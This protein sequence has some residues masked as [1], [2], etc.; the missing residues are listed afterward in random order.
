MRAC[1]AA[2]TRGSSCPIG[3]TA[4]APSEWPAIPSRSRF[5]LFQNGL[6]VGVPAAFTPSAHG[7]GLDGV[8][9][10]KSMADFVSVG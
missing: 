7:Y 1:A 8:D 9:S 6:N 4:I 2:S 10:T 5:T 3:V